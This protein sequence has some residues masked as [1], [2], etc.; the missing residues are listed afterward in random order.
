MTESPSNQKM[1][2]DTMKSVNS[3]WDFEQSGDEDSSYKSGSIATEN[4]AYEEVAGTG[5]VYLSKT[6]YCLVYKH[7]SHPKDAP[8]YICIRGDSCGG[9]TRGYHTK[10]RINTRA[11]PGHYQGAYENGSLKAAL[12]GTLLTS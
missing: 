2:R 3:E 4:E 8:A 5:T 11:A 10:L 7:R 1:D 6:S 9:R 12:M